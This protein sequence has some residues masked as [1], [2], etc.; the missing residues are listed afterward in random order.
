MANVIQGARSATALP[1]PLSFLYGYQTII[2]DYT[3]QTALLLLLGQEGDQDLNVC[4][5]ILLH[6]KNLLEVGD[7]YLLNSAAKK[8]ITP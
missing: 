5:A 8:D 7:Q 2:S 1:L 4:L 6:T 3:C